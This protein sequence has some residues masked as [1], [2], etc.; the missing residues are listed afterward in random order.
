MNSSTLPKMLQRETAHYIADMILELRNMAKSAQ[1]YQIMVPL[2]YSYYEAFSVANKV[3]IPPA[4]A[5]RLKELA[6][7][8]AELEAV[9]DDY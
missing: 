4:E 5:E 2:E 6:R 1:L 7:T 9:A 3:E 8:A